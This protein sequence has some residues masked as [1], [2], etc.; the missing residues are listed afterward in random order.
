MTSTSDGQTQIEAE[1]QLQNEANGQAQ[2]EAGS[3]AEKKIKETKISIV[4]DDTETEE[5]ADHD[6]DDRPGNVLESV[7]SFWGHALRKGRVYMYDC[8]KIFFL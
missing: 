7:F 5:T 2:N 8:L 6:T 3:E 4:K 1:C